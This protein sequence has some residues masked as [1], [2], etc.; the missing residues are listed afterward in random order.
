MSYS[1]WMEQ[2]NISADECTAAVDSMYTYQQDRIVI[3]LAEITKLRNAH[4]SHRGDTAA[5]EAA[6]EKAEEISRAFAE[7]IVRLQGQI[8]NYKSALEAVHKD[9]L[10]RASIDHD[11]GKVV[12]VGMSVWHKVCDALDP[13]FIEGGDDE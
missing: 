7:D 6:L 8:D 10:M 9:L 11:G 13:K 5:L 1:E 4:A 2:E 12:D 3:L